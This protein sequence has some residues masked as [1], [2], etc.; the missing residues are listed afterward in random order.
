MFAIQKQPLMVCKSLFAVMADSRKCNADSVFLKGGTEVFL[1]CTV[2]RGSS[3]H[4][5]R[6]YQAENF[7][8]NTYIYYI[9]YSFNNICN[10][11]YLNES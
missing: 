10:K 11:D 2:F 7:L 4:V 1:M 5:E 8:Q 9:G 6:I 3:P